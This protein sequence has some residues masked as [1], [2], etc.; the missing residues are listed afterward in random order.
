VQ[1]MTGPIAQFLNGW[2]IDIANCRRVGAAPWRAFA[3]RDFG[4]PFRI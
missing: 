2:V 1:A 3:R 4:L